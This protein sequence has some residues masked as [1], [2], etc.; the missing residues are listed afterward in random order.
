MV[1]RTV[2][3]LRH[4]RQVSKININQSEQSFDWPMTGH[5]FSLA[6]PEEM[7]VV[8]LNRTDRIRLISASSDVQ[9]NVGAVITQSWP[10]GI[11]QVG[12]EQN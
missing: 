3:S 9:H 1:Q 5:T 8:S 6:T 10:K 12:I 4:D 7:F 2:Y 11:Q